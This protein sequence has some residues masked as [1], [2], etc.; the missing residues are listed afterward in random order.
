MHIP[1]DALEP[2]LT[3]DQAALVLAEVMPRG[4]EGQLVTPSR[5]TLYKWMA[6]RVNPM[7][8][9]TRPGTGPRTGN[10]S[11][12]MFLRSHI[13]RWFYDPAAYWTEQ[14]KQKAS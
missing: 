13:L 3:L 12:R 6:L 7:P 5:R 4:K 2:R 1:E 8:F 14:K 10:T 9:L 11:F